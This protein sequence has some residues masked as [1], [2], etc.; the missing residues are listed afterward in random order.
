MKVVCI[1]NG[2]MDGAMDRKVNLTIGK[3]YQ[4]IGDR[5]SDTD[6]VY[7]VINDLGKKGN[8]YHGRFESIDITRE[9][10]LEEILEIE[11]Y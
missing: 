4:A 8:Y 6:S 5:V 2:E 7:V 11:K 3:V 10:K 1:N 9:R